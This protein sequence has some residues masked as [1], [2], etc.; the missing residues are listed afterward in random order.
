[1]ASDL[2]DMGADVTNFSSTHSETNKSNKTDIVD[3]NQFLHTVFGEQSN[4]ACSIV[5][6]FTGNP[7]NVSSKNWFGRPW[8]DGQMN[9][10]PH[11]NNYFSLAQFRPNDAGQYRRIKS[12]FH[13]L[14]AVM[15]DDI[16]SKVGMDRLT[17]SPSWL[18]ETSPGNYQA[19]YLLEEPITKIKVADQL[20][21][22]IINAGLCD[23][24]A[25]GPTTRLARLPIAQNGKHEPPFSCRMKTWSPDRRYSIQQLIDG[26]QLEIIQTERSRQEKSHAPNKSDADDDSVWIPCPEENIVLTA[27]RQ[28]NLYKAPL[29]SGKHDITC[30]WKEEHTDSIDSGTAYFEPDDNWPIGGLKCLHG[31]CAD[32]N[33][34]DLLRLLDLNI[35]EARMKPIIHVISGEIHRVVDAAERE[36]ARSK[37]Y[38]QRGGLIVTVFSD[39]GTQEIRVQEVSQPAL[40][41]ALAGIAIWDRF[42]ARA[43]DWVRIDPPPRHATVLSNAANYVHLPVLNG[44]ARQP[45]LRLDGSLMNIAGYDP[46]SG[47]FGVFDARLFVIPD[48]PSRMQAESALALLQDLLEEFSFATEFDRSAALA[49]ILTAATRVSLAHAPM[50]HVRAHTVG[51]GKSYLCELITAFATPQRGT[52]ASFPANDEEC[53]KLLLAELLRAPPVIEFDN[54]TCDLWAHKSLCTVLTSEFIR[55]RILG[56]SKT[57]IVSTRTLLLSSGNNVGP[58]QDMTRRCITIYLDPMIEIP[59][60]RTY[61]RPDLIRE[62]L[63]DRARYISAALTVVRA[64]ITAGKPKT[65]CKSLASYGDWSDLCRQPLLW[66]GCSDPAASIFEALSEDPER[67]LLARFL[68]VWQSMFGKSPAMLRDAM[69]RYQSHFGE[70]DELGEVLHDIADER[71]VINRRKLGWWLKRHAGQIADGLRLVHCEGT[72]AAA[73]WR[74]ESVSTVLSVSAESTEKTVSTAA[75]YRR[76]S[77]GE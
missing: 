37:Q 24:G 26:L 19:G 4:G 67:E 75:E 45:Y 12:H 43:K 60:T 51:S 22:A 3:N 47:M 35:M 57:A 1:M 65:N 71:G 18:L 11:V 36:L 72:R 30:P 68:N 8:S 20:M 34:R 29:G 39:P 56:E 14:Y 73:K 38:Y 21:N 6:S 16:G 40:V 9:F 59:A 25:N 28:R 55:G 32:R 54:L 70:Q 2:L 42:D 7:T 5:V 15:L 53:Q 66:L 31:H 69:K 46:I 13:G 33:I 44:L 10:I 49:A 63:Q 58:I 77:S 52:P 61:K 64:W 23:P 41:R 27:L 50:F 74:V 17:L 48:T 62:I 76:A